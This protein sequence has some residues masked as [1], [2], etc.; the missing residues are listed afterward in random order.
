MADATLREIRQRM[1]LLIQTYVVPFQTTTTNKGTVFDTAPMNL[2]RANLPAIVI[3]DGATTYTGGTR[4]RNEFMATVQFNI[5]LYQGEWQPNQNNNIDLSA[6]DDTINE[7]ENL[8]LIRRG[9]ENASN[10]S[11]VEDTFLQTASPIQVIGYIPIAG[12]GIT[13]QTQYV[14]KRIILSVRYSRKANM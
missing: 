1:Q 2:T 9:L 8:F 11:C 3:T 4:G 12:A 13:S 7:L 14:H 6:I 10:Q 5:S